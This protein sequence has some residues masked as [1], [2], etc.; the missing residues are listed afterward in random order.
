MCY[1]THLEV[2]V[3]FLDRT[4]THTVNFTLSKWKSY[5]CGFYEKQLS[6]RQDLTLI[7]WSFRIFK[8]DASCR[9]EVVQSGKCQRVKETIHFN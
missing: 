1:R 4:H 6:R 3:F 2:A 8:S 9:T 7:L 5:F